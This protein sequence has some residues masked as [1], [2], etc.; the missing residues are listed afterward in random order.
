[1]LLQCAALLIMAGRLGSMIGPRRSLVTGLGLCAAASALCGAAQRGWVGGGDVP[2]QDVGGEV[3][4]LL[5]GGDVKGEAKAA[6][7]GR[8]LDPCGVHGF[9][10]GAVGG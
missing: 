3:G 10:G 6:G 5:A 9:G 8:S 2:P 4:V 1:L 7:P